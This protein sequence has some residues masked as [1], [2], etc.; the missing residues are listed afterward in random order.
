MSEY[1]QGFL[2]TPSSSPTCVCLTFNFSDEAKEEMLGDKVENEQEKRNK[3]MEERLKQME[4]R[5]KQN[6]L[7]KS[8]KMM[9]QRLKEMEERLKQEE[10][11]DGESQQVEG[12]QLKKRVIEESKSNDVQ[13]KDIQEQGRLDREE[14]SVNDSTAHANSKEDVMWPDIRGTVA[15]RY[16]IGIHNPLFDSDQDL[17]TNPILN[18]IFPGKPV[19]HVLRASMTSVESLKSSVEASL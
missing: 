8:N 16:I 15:C 19:S 10:R 2:Q 18:L 5:L 3:E 12:E 7:E 13:A 6:E 14:S 4:E 1:V 9:E 11:R 17:K